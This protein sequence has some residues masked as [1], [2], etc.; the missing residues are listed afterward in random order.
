MPRIQ[1]LPVLLL[2]A[3]ACVP[4][5][6]AAEPTADGPLV[7]SLSVRTG[8]TT[9]RFLLQVTNASEEPVGLVFPSGQTYDFAVRQGGRELWRW[10]DGMGFTQAIRNV[11]VAP[12]ETLEFEEAWT[13][14]AGA[15]GDM[16]AVA[17]LTS[18]SHPLRRTAVFRLP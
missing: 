12:G 5:V 14:P 7:S 4:A 8:E 9:V 11:T 16:E 15:A 6:P 13:P 10:S 2:L 1:L 3:A 18:S 17:T